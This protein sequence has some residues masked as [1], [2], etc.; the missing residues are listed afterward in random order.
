MRPAVLS[1]FARRDIIEAVAW[2]ASDNPLAARGFREAVG[3]ALRLIGQ[4]PNV[5]AIRRDL[6]TERIRFMVLRG[7]SYILVYAA[8]T[9][10]PRILRV[11]HGARHLPELLRDLD[12]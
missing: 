5:G 12:G 3:K 11:L 4:H 6:A 2:I 7:Y 1:P 9:E 8:D 10:P